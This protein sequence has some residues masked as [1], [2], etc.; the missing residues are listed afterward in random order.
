MCGGELAAVA[1]VVGGNMIYRQQAVSYMKIHLKETATTSEQRLILIGERFFHNFQSL[2]IIGGMSYQ[3]TEAFCHYLGN[4]PDAKKIELVEFHTF[5]K[6]NPE[7][8]RDRKIAQNKCRN[9]RKNALR[10]L[11]RLLLFN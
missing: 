2:E 5:G 8:L 11:H 1:D 10:Q 7:K 9:Y 6:K 3:Y 4:S